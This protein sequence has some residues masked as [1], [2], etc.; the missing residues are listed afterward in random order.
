[1]SVDAAASSTESLQRLTEDSDRILTYMSHEG[2]PL[3]RRQIERFI[4]I[5]LAWCAAASVV[6]DQL[7]VLGQ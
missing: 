6:L 3:T 5:R 1:M 4:M 2:E 7:S